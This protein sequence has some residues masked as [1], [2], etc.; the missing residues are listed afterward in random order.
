MTE[1]SFREMKTRRDI[2]GADGIMDSI[3]VTFIPNLA[4]PSGAMSSWSSAKLLHRLR[5]TQVQKSEIPLLQRQELKI[6]KTK[7]KTWRGQLQNSFYSRLTSF[8]F[9][10]SEEQQLV[11]AFIV[12][13]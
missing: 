13:I 4:S 3:I 9:M 6:H 11:D 5:I 8:V 12:M 2:L 10:Y 7:R 1:S